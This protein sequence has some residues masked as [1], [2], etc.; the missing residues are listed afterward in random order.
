ARR[1]ARRRRATLAGFAAL[2]AAASVLAAFALV[3]RKEARDDARLA[4]ARQLAA[5]AEADLEVDPERSILLAIEAA[6]TTRRH[7]GTML[8]EAEQALHNA[9][10][11]SRVLMTVS[12]IGRTTGA[13]IG[14]VVAAAPDAPWFVTAD[15][16]AETASIRDAG[17]GEKLETLAG[18]K[19]QVLAVGVSPDGSRVATGSLDGT[20]RLWNAATGDPGHVLLAHKGGV[21]ATRFSGDGTRLATLGADRAVRV[22]DV[23]TGRE[24][25]SFEG[26]HERTS[27]DSAWG[28]GVAF[29]GRDRIAVSPWARG[30]LPSPVVAKVLDISSGDQVAVVE[31]PSGNSQVFDLDVSPDGTRLVA[32][33]AEGGQLQLYSLPSGRQ[34]DEVHGHGVGVLD[35]EFSR[36]GRLVATGGVDGVAKL[37]EVER[38]KLRAGLTLRARRKTIS[39]VSL[40]RT[41]SRLFTAASAE[42]RAWDVSPTGRGEVLR[43]PGP[44]TDRHPAIAFT[45]DG[46]RLVA[47]SG[48]PGT[49]RV[50]SMDTGKLLL[51]LDRN[52]RANARDRAVIGIDVSPDGSRIATAGADGSVRIFDAETGEQLVF[53]PRL[54]CVRERGC[55][56]NRAV[57]SPDGSRIATTGWDAKVGILDART[58]R[59]LRVLHGFKPEGD[60]TYPVAW[61][62]D[63]TR[64]LAMA[65]KGTRIWDPRTG[66]PLVAMPQS[67][68]PASAAIWNPD[69]RQVLTMSGAGA[70]VWDASSGTLLRTLETDTGTSDLAFSRDG[71]RLAIG[72]LN[73]QTY[74]VGIFD[75]PAGEE[76]F[77]MRDGARRVA[78]SPDGKLL[79][80]VRQELSTRFVGAPVVRVWT[81]DPERLLR[82]AR[83]RVTRRL[84]EDECRRYLQRSCSEDR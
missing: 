16:D 9:L 26:V 39:S 56:V 60:G 70:H 79:A 77:W 59:P 35:V 33:R 29:V 68:G 14:H 15:R 10:A 2:A 22:W 63:G 66:R 12:G 74:A 69:G 20:A 46:R 31:D 21:L 7:D 32:G 18:H 28:E 83:S 71:S 81:L 42:A 13:G 6:E 62:P 25:R 82:I 64:L 57:F 51:V 30:T 1:R 55:R 50:W 72:A 58:G 73:E 44:E 80:G 47:T 49:V 54:H 27:V 65:P 67:G 78:F 23:R 61:S 19:A 40:D 36:D 48:S 41:A 3:L 76:I 24:L 34:L 4:T 43:R 75:W 37:W 45:P 11:T 8:P 38:G 5:A 53:V 17:T 52:A 84:T